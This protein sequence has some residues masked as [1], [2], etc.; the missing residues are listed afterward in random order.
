MTRL[1]GLYSLV[2]EFCGGCKKS[3]YSNYCTKTANLIS[4]LLFFPN[5]SN[6]LWHFSF[7][8]SYLSHREELVRYSI[9]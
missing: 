3:M 1:E 2:S 5:N 9:K 7:T 4:F 8:I 6:I